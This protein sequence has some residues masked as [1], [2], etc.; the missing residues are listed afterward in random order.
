M[1]DDIFVKHAHEWVGI[2]RERGADT[3]LEEKL[4]SIIEKKDEQLSQIR[5]EIINHLS[6][7][8]P[9]AWATGNYDD[10][11]HQWE[12]RTESLIKKLSGDD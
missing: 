3:S 8:A 10:D 7:A 12:K 11:A 9:L 6:E 2:I 5:G 4:L 1:N